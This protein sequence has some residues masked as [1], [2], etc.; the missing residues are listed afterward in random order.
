MRFIILHLSEL[1]SQLEQQHPGVGFNNQLYSSTVTPSSFQ[2]F[3][4]VKSKKYRW[5][6]ACE[7][8]HTS[9]LKFSRRGPLQQLK[10]N[11]ET[12]RPKQDR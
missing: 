1:Y 12:N 5:K 4:P 11:G 10:S 7:N 8:V 9:P 2:G 3:G 6:E